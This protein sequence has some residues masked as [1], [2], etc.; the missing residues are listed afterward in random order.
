MS[1]TASNVSVGKPQAAGGV[2]A[3]PTSTTAPTS[4]LTTLPQALK[5][6]GYVS[7]E[8]LTNGIETETADITAWG[9]DR[10]LSVR[11][12]RSESFSWTFIES[13]NED[14]LAECYGPNNVS[15]AGG[16]LT[17]IHN[18]EE[19]PARMY[20]FEILMTG[21]RVK[22][23]V[24]PNSKIDEVGDVVYVDGE[25]VG[26]TVT[27]ACYPDS[28]GNTVYEYIAALDGGSGSA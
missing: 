25:P 2:Y 27:L 22:R 13:L 1:G 21:D 19:L 23:I 12:S 18:S 3:G 10:V 24:V 28:N 6:L 8:G 4:A 15:S 26:Y 16:E 9:G 14:V 17:V 11:T 20:V 5:A 7:D